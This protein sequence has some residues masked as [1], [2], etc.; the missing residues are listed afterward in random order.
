[1]QISNSNSTTKS[2]RRQDAKII[3]GSSAWRLCVLAVNLD[4]GIYVKIMSC[5]EYILKSRRELSSL[6]TIT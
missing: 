5:K 2:P 3:F 4:F 6:N 1:M